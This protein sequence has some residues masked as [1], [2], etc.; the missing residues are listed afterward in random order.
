MNEDDVFEFVA[1]DVTPGLME[2]LAKAGHV[3]GSA[4]APATTAAG[5]ISSIRLRQPIAA[6]ATYHSR[7][8]SGQRQLR[9]QRH[10]AAATVAVMAASPTAAD[11]N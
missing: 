8:G 2:S 10:T 7:G 11:T 3:G 6:A 9:E 4:W 1:A 5:D